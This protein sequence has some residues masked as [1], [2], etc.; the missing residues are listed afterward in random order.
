MTDRRRAKRERERKIKEQ[1]S[2]EWRESSVGAFISDSIFLGL[3]P[4]PPLSVLINF[5]SI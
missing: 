5:L 2:M 1:R 4:A 3:W